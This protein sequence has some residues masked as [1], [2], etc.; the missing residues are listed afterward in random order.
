MEIES[1]QQILERRGEIEKELL[2]MLKETESNFSLENIKKIIYNE[3]GQD[4][5]TDITAM[6]DTGQDRAKLKNVLKII[7]DA[8]NY[9][10]HKSLGGISPTEKVLKYQEKQKQDGNSIRI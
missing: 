8:W 4:D 3:K 5:L 10:P 2:D 9:F 1:K 6:F 7:N